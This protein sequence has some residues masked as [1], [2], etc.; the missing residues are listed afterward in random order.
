MRFHPHLTSPFE[1]EEFYTKLCGTLYS[2]Y[3]R[4]AFHMPP[5]SRGN[6]LSLTELC[7]IA[8]GLPPL[9]MTGWVVMAFATCCNNF[10][11]LL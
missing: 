1:G 6:K 9:A 5:C 7:E 11:F 4:A 3:C 8:S 2:Q 10:T